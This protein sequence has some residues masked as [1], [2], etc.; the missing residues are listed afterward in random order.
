MND[1][2]RYV[3]HL[4]SV[5]KS[6]ML[7]KA[8]LRRIKLRGDTAQALCASKDI[9]EF[10]QNIHQHL[11]TLIDADIIRGD[12]Q[13]IKRNRDVIK[14]FVLTD[15]LM[16]MDSI[17]I[18]ST[19]RIV[20]LNSRSG[21]RKSNIGI[22]ANMG[23]RVNADIGPIS[24]VSDMFRACKLD[25]RSGSYGSY[26]QA[27]DPNDDTHRGTYTVHIYAEDWP[28]VAKAACLERLHD[29][30]KTGSHMDGYIWSTCKPLIEKHWP[31]IAEHV[32]NELALGFSLG[33][34]EDVLRNILSDNL[35]IGTSSSRLHD[36]T[37]E[38]LPELETLY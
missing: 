10:K 35:S 15:K 21:T 27:N 26:R 2:A 33:V 38:A 18:S 36:L 4:K 34:S 19:D 1:K 23:M 25:V 17:F 8:C 37:A 16:D 14:Q 29:M 11:L 3:K 13:H 12:D 6:H 28:F 30:V 32:F 7:K 20:E 5:A 24:S 22:E 9:N 31:D